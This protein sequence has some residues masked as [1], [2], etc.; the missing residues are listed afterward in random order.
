[1][2]DDNLL[3]DV[4]DLTQRLSFNA[5]LDGHNVPAIQ[6]TSPELADIL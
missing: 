2:R 1:M 4:R 3:R 6:S 5:S